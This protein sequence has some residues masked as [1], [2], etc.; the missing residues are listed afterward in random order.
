M[1]VFVGEENGGCGAIPFCDDPDAP[2]GMVGRFVSGKDTVIA[3]AD[4][5]IILTLI[6]VAKVAPITGFVAGNAGENELCKL[7]VPC[8]F[9][10]H[11]LR[12]YEHAE[13]KSFHAEAPFVLS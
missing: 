7:A 8:H 3:G 11:T 13:L 10:M 12:G 4:S 1:S 2:V 6:T 9:V 5:F